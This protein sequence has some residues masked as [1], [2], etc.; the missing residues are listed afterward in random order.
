[1]SISVAPFSSF[2]RGVKDRKLSGHPKSYVYAKVPNPRPT[3][4]GPNNST[5]Q[6]VI[7]V[8]SH[9]QNSSTLRQVLIP[10]STSSFYFHYQLTRCNIWLRPQRHYPSPCSIAVHEQRKAEEATENY[11]DFID[12]AKTVL[13]GYMRSNFDA[14]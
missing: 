8:L 13:G 2:F 3:T 10:I 12:I 14:V 9:Y 7:Q 11:G 1:M 5:G 6:H 4:H